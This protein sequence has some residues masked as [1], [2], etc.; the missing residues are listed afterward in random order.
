VAGCQSGDTVLIDQCVGQSPTSQRVR[1][2]VQTI[3]LD[4]ALA[5]LDRSSCCRLRDRGPSRR[6]CAGLG[7]VV[8]LNIDGLVGGFSSWK[9]RSILSEGVE[10]VPELEGEWNASK[11]RGTMRLRL[12]LF[13]DILKIRSEFA[14]GFVVGWL[15][16]GC[17][18]RL[19]GCRRFSRCRE[20]WCLC[21]MLSRRESR[22]WCW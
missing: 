17:I 2:W 21:R 12:L 9:S 4:G 13:D 19:E 11:K 15:Q 3:I 14:S 22:T 20:V 8:A 10:L 18:K 6:K 1:R 16:V 7:S 5:L